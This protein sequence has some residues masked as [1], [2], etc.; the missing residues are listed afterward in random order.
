MSKTPAEH[1]VFRITIRCEQQAC[2][3]EDLISDKSAQH[4]AASGSSEKW[5]SYLHTFLLQ[6]LH[7]SPGSRLQ[8]F[9]ESLQLSWFHR[10]WSIA[11]H[12]WIIAYPPS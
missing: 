3:V 10:S 11:F 1:D 12:P 7:A 4:E 6:G 9:R 5:P 2:N 8:P